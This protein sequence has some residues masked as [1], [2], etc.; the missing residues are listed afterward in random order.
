M[1]TDI[2]N[3][4]FVYYMGPLTGTTPR[5]L[6]Q[7]GQCKNFTYFEFEFGDWGCETQ[8]IGLS[9]CEDLDIFL[10]RTPGIDFT[11]GTTTS[12]GDGNNYRASSNTPVPQQGWKLPGTFNFVPLERRTTRSMLNAT[13]PS[14]SWTPTAMG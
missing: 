7:L 5:N 10:Q 14:T 6:I 9:S 13:T 4:D 11:T 1:R 3:L 8:N 2:T 12:P